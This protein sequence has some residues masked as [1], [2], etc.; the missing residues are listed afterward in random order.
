LLLDA[1]KAF[2]PDVFRISSYYLRN[3]YTRLDGIGIQIF[4]AAW[5]NIRK[6]TSAPLATLEELSKLVVNVATWRPK[7][8]N[9]IDAAEMPGIAVV[10]AY[11][12][13]NHAFCDR[14]GGIT[15]L[16]S[17]V[18]CNDYS[19]AK[20]WPLAHFLA[21]QWM[22]FARECRLTIGSTRPAATLMYR[23]RT[24]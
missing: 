20:A 5:Q 6:S 9:W 24:H 18:D 4:A 15:H 8:G 12:F 17:P 3:D 7:D 1:V 22:I 16:A 21:S 14:N 13:L 23:R 11:M 19:L 10:V 2:G